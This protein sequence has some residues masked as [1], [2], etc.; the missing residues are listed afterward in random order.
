MKSRTWFTILIIVALGV[1]AWFA[2]SYRNVLIPS[3]AESVIRGLELQGT[4]D[5]VADIE[6]DLNATSLGELN[7]ELSDIEKELQNAGL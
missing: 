2:Y 1:I 7:S 4:S 3:S 6:K 5:E